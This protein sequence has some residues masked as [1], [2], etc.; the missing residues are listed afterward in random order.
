[1][2]RAWVCT[3]NPRYSGGAGR[4][5]YLFSFFA[6]IDLAAVLPSLI[7]LGGLNLT[8]LR[9]ARIFRILKLA[10]LGGFSLAIDTLG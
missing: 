5:R 8:W 7:A 9:S 1:V 3:S 6:L 10:R 2:L 4:L